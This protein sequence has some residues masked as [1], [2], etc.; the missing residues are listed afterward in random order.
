MTEQHAPS[1]EASLHLLNRAT[2][3]HRVW[4]DMMSALGAHDQVLLI[5]DG[6]TSLAH[7]PERLIALGERLHVLEEDLRARGLHLLEIAQDVQRVDM[8]GFVALTE[9]CRHI[10]SWF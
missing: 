7:P 8:K 6:V 10:I 3:G 1:A 5:E 2:H 9:R 4:E